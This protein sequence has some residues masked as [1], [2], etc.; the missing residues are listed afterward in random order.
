MKNKK[1]VNMTLREYY[2]GI[3]MRILDP[4]R[5]SIKNGK[6]GIDYKGFTK[7]CED[8]VDNFMKYSK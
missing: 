7:Q 6:Q 1:A 8:L 5:H 2:L 4:P 3:A